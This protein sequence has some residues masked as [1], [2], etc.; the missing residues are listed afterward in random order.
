M[1]I[2]I[3]KYIKRLDIHLPYKNVN[4]VRTGFGQRVC[5]KKDRERCKFLIFYLKLFVSLK[6]V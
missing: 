4:I 5:L 1:Y 2:C 6:H 3:Y